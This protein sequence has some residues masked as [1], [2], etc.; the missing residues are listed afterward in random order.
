MPSLS[1]GRTDRRFFA[2][3]PPTTGEPGTID[4]D[5]LITATARTDMQSERHDPPAN[6]RTANARNYE[7]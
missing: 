4:T 3:Y 1:D 2:E 6:N 7:L 5:E